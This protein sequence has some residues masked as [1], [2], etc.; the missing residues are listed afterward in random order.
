MLREFRCSTNHHSPEHKHYLS[1]G[2]I[3]FA[4]QVTRSGNL[5]SGGTAKPASSLQYMH[6]EHLD[7]MGLIHMNGRVYD[8]LIGRFMSADPFIQA[9]D[10]LQSHNRYAY[11]MKN[12]L[13]L[14]DP[15][16][17]WKFSGNSG[18]GLPFPVSG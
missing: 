13:N 12:P 11:V 1:A 14:T 6:R 3:V 18:S 15:S 7:E 16:G 8:P 10:N 4:M 17:Y 2:G 9:P 5:A